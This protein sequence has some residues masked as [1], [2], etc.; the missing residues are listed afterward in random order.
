VRI[1]S[2]RGKTR[3]TQFARGASFRPPA[4][5]RYIDV[6]KS[7]RPKRGTYRTRNGWVD[8]HHDRDWPGAIRLDADGPVWIMPKGWT[9]QEDK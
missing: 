7:N 1:L 6:S 3:S 5:A 2:V 8:R 9:L 4:E